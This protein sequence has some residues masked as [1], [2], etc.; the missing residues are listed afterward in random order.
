MSWC[1][2]KVVDKRV[3]EG[4]HLVDFQVWVDKQLDQTTA[5]GTALVEL[6]T[7]GGVAPALRF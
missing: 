4:A 6:P 3:E 5:R 1:R 7:R 2:A